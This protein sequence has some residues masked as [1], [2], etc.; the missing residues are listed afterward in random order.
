[1]TPATE[2]V[3]LM[4]ITPWFQALVTTGRIPRITAEEAEEIG[5]AV[6]A[7]LLKLARRKEFRK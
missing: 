2:A 1:M 3:T 6:T 7:S 4:A 5:R